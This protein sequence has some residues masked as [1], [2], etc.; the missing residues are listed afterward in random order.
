MER[1]IQWGIV[2]P[3]RIA[4]KLA[5]EWSLI[6][7]A[8]L[9]AVAS[10]DLERATAFA[11][12]FEIER[13]YGSYAELFADPEV[14]IVYI[15]VPH[16]FHH[17]LVLEALAAGKA[18]LCEKPMGINAAECEA[19]IEAAREHGVFLM[20]AVKTRFM[21]AVRQAQTWVGEG[22]LGKVGLLQAQFCF[23]AGPDPSGRHLNP[24]LAG[25]AMLDLGVYPLTVAE[26]LLGANPVEV[27]ATATLASTGVDATTAMTLR[28]DSGAVAQLCVSVAMS[29]GV[30]A[31]LWGEHGYLE[32]PRSNQAQSATLHLD[33]EIE[34]FTQDGSG[35]F[36]FEVEEANRCLREGLLESPDMPHEAS[37]RMARWHDEVLA[38]VHGQ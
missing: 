23:D 32:L 24:D 20:E 26:L 31:R 2:G 7:N 6:D 5:S 35:V 38:Q 3:G 25:G 8:R 27:S 16:N 14:D 9:T 36:R 17:A 37:L 19:Q 34:T 13:A 4:R 29:G 21:P 30:A 18:V 11:E 22:R 28:Y 12:D 1:A 33:G 15:A 10:R